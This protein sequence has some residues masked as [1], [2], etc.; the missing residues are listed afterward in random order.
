MN[1]EAFLKKAISLSQSFLP[2]E[3]NK[4]ACMAQVSGEKES[5]VRNWLF[6]NKMPSKGKR[7][8]I[9]DKFGV[10]DDHLFNEAEFN[11]PLTKYDEQHEYFLVP[12]LKLEELYGVTEKVPLPVQQRNV[13]NLSKNILNHIQDYRKTYCFQAERISFEPFIST[14]DI[15][16]VNTTAM[17]K[18][19]QFCLHL[20][21]VIQIVKLVDRNNAILNDGNEITIKDDE[22]LFPIL[23]TLSP[24]YVNYA[25]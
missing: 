23:L 22:H 17:V 7:L 10:D 4:T 2:K 13:I 3:K 12:V 1:N 15:L 25:D 18:Q 14:T 9:A 16:F 24:G 21:R 5:T 6:N 11:I 19:G 20:G 8:G